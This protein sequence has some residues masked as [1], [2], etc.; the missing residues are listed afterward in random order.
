[1]PVF[2]R[3][4]TS[5]KEHGQVLPLFALVLPLI[6]LFVGFAID[7]G[8]AY[9]TKANLSKAVDSACLM[10]MRNLYQGQ[11]QAAA[12]AR[13]AFALNY[14]Q[15]GRDTSSPVVNVS[16][17]TDPNNNTLLNVDA[18]AT[19]NTFFIRVL[20]K[21]KTLNVKAN[22]QATRAKLIMSLVL[23]DS[24]SMK[25]NGGWQA[26]PPAVTDFVN[27]FDDLNDHVAMVSFSSNAKVKVTTRTGFKGPI[28]SAVR[29]M[30]FSGGTFSQSGMLNAQTQN[31]SVA[32]TPGDNAVKVVVFFTDGWANMNQ[33]NLNCGGSTKLVNYGGCS[34]VE[35]ALSPP[36]CSG[37][38]FLDPNTGN[39][40]SCSATKFPSQQAGTMMPLTPASTGQL[41]I[42]NDAMYRTVKVADAM[43]GENVPTV[44]YSVGLGDK[45]NQNFLYQVA[46]DPNSPTFDP[47]KPVGM[48]VFAPDCPSSLCDSELDD[49]F[50]TIASSILLRLTQ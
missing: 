11:P 26:L 42:S 23:D 28:N 14:G 12:I 38:S 5:K 47:N 36:W 19:I 44:V 21:W 46:N 25:K 10:G 33:D 2:H 13:S 3:G 37:V 39:S 24:G 9:I 45:I 34:P 8:F 27:M 17:S 20:P 7:F 22:A 1:M 35:A 43:R 41:N 32:V 50:Q 16:F 31:D 40:V 29:S 49:V 4:K 6:I 18:T 15:S 48:A 30:G